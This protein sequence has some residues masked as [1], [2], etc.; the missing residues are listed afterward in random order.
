MQSIDKCARMVLISSF[1]KNIKKTV[2]EHTF[3]CFLLIVFF[4]A[5]KIKKNL[6]RLVSKHSIYIWVPF[7][8]GTEPHSLK[9]TTKWL[10]TC[11]CVLVCVGNVVCLSWLSHCVTYILNLMWAWHWITAVQ[12]TRKCQ[13]HAYIGRCVLMMLYARPKF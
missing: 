7:G 5:F 1:D 3:F 8:H 4:C 13:T 11:L 10:Q 6:M 2:R 12:Q 9:Q